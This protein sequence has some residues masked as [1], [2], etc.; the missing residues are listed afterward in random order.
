MNAFT[1]YHNIY[2]TL[3]QTISN[4]ETVNWIWTIN[5]SIHLIDLTFNLPEIKNYSNKD[6]H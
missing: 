1:N 6:Q 3:I 2:Y 4:I 5:A